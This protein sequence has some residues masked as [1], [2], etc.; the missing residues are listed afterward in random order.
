LACKNFAP[1]PLLGKSKG[2]PATPQ[3]TQVYAVNENSYFYKSL[4]GLIK[5]RI[6]N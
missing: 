6:T 2:Q 5:L 4:S 1:K 3:L